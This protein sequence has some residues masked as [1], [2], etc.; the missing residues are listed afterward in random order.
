ML[1]P[2]KMVDAFRAIGY[3][4]ML[5]HGFSGERK[6]F[7]KDIKRRIQAGETFSFAY[8]ETSTMPTILTDP[9]HLPKH[10]IMDFAF[11]RFLRKHNV[12]IGLFYCDLYWKFNDYGLH[13]GHLEKK[14]A[15]LCYQYDLKNYER[16]LT[17]FYIPN[18]KC[19]EFLNNR[20]LSLISRELPPGCD[21]IVLSN[22]RAFMEDGLLRIFYVGGIGIH[23]NLTELFKAVSDL[24]TCD[25][26]VC[27]RESEW[28]KEKENY[29]PYI[30]SNIH[31]VHSSEP[32][33]YYRNADICT[34][35]FEPNQYRK[36]AVPFK[37]FEYLSYEK[38]IIC[39]DETWISS[40]IEENKIGW[41]VTFERTAIQNMLSKI[42]RDSE[43]YNSKKKKCKQVK[44]KNLWTQRAKIVES[45][46]SHYE[47]IDE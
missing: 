35:V 5:I 24:P 21:E 4:V 27:C 1:R 29:L 17:V 37:S 15:I 25:L 47:N 45:D 7:I 28:D 46:L 40:F 42:L 11:F 39:T 14:I 12:P 43:E 26:T 6:R 9:N 41:S 19:L 32:Q 44:E 10:V 13:M 18:K 36:M 33:L 30:N 22:N 38:P 23:Y 8:T 34:L 3:D 16:L 31:I 20:P 2:R